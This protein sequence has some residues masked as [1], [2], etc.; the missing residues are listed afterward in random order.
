MVSIF[1]QKAVQKKTHA[2]LLE[3]SRFSQS[4]M[5]LKGKFPS[6]PAKRVN[7]M[8]PPTLAPYHAKPCERH[9]VGQED[10]HPDVEHR[11]PGSLPRQPERKLCSLWGVKG[12]GGGTPCESFPTVAAVTQT[13]PSSQN[14]SAPN[15]I[16]NCAYFSNNVQRICNTHGTR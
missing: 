10:K 11:G 12:G 16:R 7:A 13:T 5:R 15:V 9:D 6:K 4:P 14:A 3:S 8:Y 2:Y 1:R